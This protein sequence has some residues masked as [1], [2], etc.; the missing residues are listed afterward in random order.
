MI[1]RRGRRRK[2]LLDYL[3][4]KRGHWKLYIALRGD[5]ALEEVKD[6]SQ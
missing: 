3:K 4:E 6:P 2:R 1:E 5:L